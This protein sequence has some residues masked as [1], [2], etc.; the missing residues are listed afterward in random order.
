MARISLNA[1]T[2]A[3]LKP[4]AERAD[5]FDTNLPSFC[6]RVSRNGVKSFSVM[7]RHAGKLRRYTIGTYPRLS[8]AKARQEAKDALR[9]AELGEDPAAKKKVKR[10]EGSFEELAADYMTRW[11]KKRKKSWRDDQRR[12]DTYL[13][14][15]FGNIHA[16]DVSRPDI[17]AMLEEIA[18]RA[19]V[20]ANRVLALVRK[21]FNWAISEDIL[22][23]SPCQSIPRP[24]IERR[25]DRVL[26]EKELRKTWRAIESQNPQVS[27]IFKLRLLTAQ[28]GGE[29]MSMAW[30]DVDLEE[31]VWTIPAE[32]AKNRLSHRV[33]LSRPVLKILQDLNGERK[34][35]PWV[36]PRLDRPKGHFMAVQV[37][38][39]RIRKAS[40]VKF[41]AHDLRRTAASL[42]TGMEI[43]RLTVGKILNHAEAGVTAVYDRHGYDAEKKDAL[44]KW[45]RRLMVIV[46]E[47]K[48]AAEAPTK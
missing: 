25:R 33:P 9:D 47:L 16:S 28:R 34:S 46:S 14:P 27:A 3:A 8:L 43:S 26:S 18:E 35:S 42:M 44:D 36:F 24:G 21:I 37:A 12:I 2:V 32:R 10:Q 6:V 41:R 48:E 1:K 13:I 20:Q 5:Y 45:A 23:H 29:I 15:R 4:Q 19:P 17:R 40:G 11:A 7:Y 30:S 22:E 31:G 39:N 38:I